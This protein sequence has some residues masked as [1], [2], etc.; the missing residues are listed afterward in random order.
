MANTI[1]PAAKASKAWRPVITGREGPK[2]SLIRRLLEFAGSHIYRLA[3]WCGLTEAKLP[4]VSAGRTTIVDERDGNVPRY[5]GVDDGRRFRLSRP[6]LQKLQYAAAHDLFAWLGIHRIPAHFYQILLQHEDPAEAIDVFAERL[7]CDKADVRRRD[8]EVLAKLQALSQL[9]YQL[10]T[11]TGQVAQVQKDRL[12]A[13]LFFRDFRRVEELTRIYT[14][15]N[16]A[17]AISQTLQ[18]L[19]FASLEYL[20][21]VA[22][23]NRSNADGFPESDALAF[24]DEMSAV[25]VL[26]DR[27]Q[28]AQARVLGQSSR[29]GAAGT[30][31]LVAIENIL[32]TDRA[33]DLQSLVLEYERL[34]Q[35]L[36]V[37]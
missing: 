24:L 27:W 36:D 7:G 32:R 30:D 22:A 16:E 19:G 26:A 10:E 1:L 25:R 14:C 13:M 23:A 17:L 11:D 2:P 20:A 12:E 9:L 15:L 35:Q 34:A 3:L 21:A 5:M 28:S 6:S 37:K 8:P 29:G 18:P 33:A 31:R 4:A